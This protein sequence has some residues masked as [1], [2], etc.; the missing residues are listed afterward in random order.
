MVNSQK[1]E[2]VPHAPHLR[3]II[4]AN[5]Q[6]FSA[7]PLYFHSRSGKFLF[8]EIKQYEIVHIPDIPL[9]AKFFLDQ[10]IDPV[11]IQ[12]GE[13]LACLASQRKARIPVRPDAQF[14]EP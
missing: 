8:V 3:F 14:R 12:K 1:V 11:K 6:F 5:V 2:P 10:P 7:I 9:Y 13:P 4:Q